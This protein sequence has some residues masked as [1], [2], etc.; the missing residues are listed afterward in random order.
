LYWYQNPYRVT[1]NEYL[2]KFYLIFDA[3]R[4]NRSDEALVR[5]IAPYTGNPDPEALAIQFIG[6]VFQPLKQQMW[7]GPSQA[8]LEP[9]GS[10]ER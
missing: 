6:T 4:H 7:S 8:A 10:L 9:A 2:A 1:A 5:V 3:L